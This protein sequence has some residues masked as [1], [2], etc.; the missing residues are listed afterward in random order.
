MQSKLAARILGDT[1]DP[2]N[3]DYTEV[4]MKCQEF[5]LGMSAASRMAKLA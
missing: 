3:D 2:D 5:D 1:I 4:F